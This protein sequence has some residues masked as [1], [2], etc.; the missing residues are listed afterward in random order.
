MTALPTSD[1]FTERLTALPVPEGRRVRISE[2]GAVLGVRMRDVFALAREFI[3]MP[4][5]EI[6]NLLERDVHEV[7]VGACSIMDKQARRKRTPQSRRAQLYDLYMG[8]HDRINTWDL[9]DLAA[10]HVVGGYLYDKS[11]A[12]L[13]T[14]ARSPQWWER[15]TAI[16]AT[17]YF[18]RHDDLGDTFGIAEILADDPVELVQKA[19]GGWIR[20]AGKREPARLLAFLDRHAATMPRTALR[21]AVEHLG[22][23]LRAHYMGAAKRSAGSQ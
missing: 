9:V 23:D 7:R 8:R 10:P 13:Y 6:A 18:I 1:V 2:Q 15:R 14:L 11:R 19:Y 20:E 3:D 5:D 4:P 17:F 21:Y 22:S 16:V 12:P